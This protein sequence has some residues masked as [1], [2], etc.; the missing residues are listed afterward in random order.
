MG[1]K[2]TTSQTTN[3]TQTAAPP[4]WT[5]PGIQSASQMVTDAMKANA[6]GTPYGGNFVA[7]PDAARTNQQIAAYDQA[8][9]RVGE[10][11]T[12]AE[13][14]MRDLYA[15]RDSQ[16]LLQNAITAS[17]DPV[18]KQLR[19]VTLPG[20]TNSALMSGAY[21]NDRA[22]GVVPGQAI[23]QATESAQRIAAELG[24]QGFQADE[25]RRLQAA[26]LL[27]SLANLSAQFATAPGDIMGA[28]SGIE[29]QMRQQVINN[30]LAKHEYGVNAPYERIAPAVQ[31][32]QALSQN[33]GT[34]TMNGR[35]VT[36]EKTSGLG[37]ILQGA[38]GLGM[39]AA[40]LG[41]FGPL[42]A[43]APAVA[44]A[45]ASAAGPAGVPVVVSDLFK[46]G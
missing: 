1:T 44:G 39:G 25:N 36:Q 18:F 45:A 8:A 38:L 17:M 22:L 15:P 20:I 29:Q 23:G 24:Y 33:W 27:P 9:Q 28:A 32:L 5:L 21:S 2:R 3:Q 14:Q 43:M 7:A 31:L 16:A 37:P 46:K 10:L 30:E 42:G 26:G 13:A 11:G 19:E 4:S 40:S 34:Q 35:S 6:P 12:F 41:A